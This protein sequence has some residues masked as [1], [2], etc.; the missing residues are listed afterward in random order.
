MPQT[1]AA[2][3]GISMDPVPATL[4]GMA[5]LTVT[6]QV[7]KE[8]RID[9]VIGILLPQIQHFFIRRAESG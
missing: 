9:V 5:R 3:D 8:G 1:Q 7:F 6:L 2:Y 4:A